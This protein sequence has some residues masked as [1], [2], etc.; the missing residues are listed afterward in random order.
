[1]CSSD[2]ENFER[3]LRHALFMYFLLSD[4]TNN[5]EK[6]RK[7]T[8]KGW[9]KA[10][11]KIG[12]DKLINAYGGLPKCS[13][14][15]YR[16]SL[17]RFELLLDVPDKGQ[18]DTVMSLRKAITDP[19]SGK[20]PLDNRYGLALRLAESIYLLHAAGLVHKFIRPESFLLIE[21]NNLESSERYPKRLGDPFLYDFL[22]V[23]EDGTSTGEK[24][25]AE[26]PKRILLYRS[27]RHSDSDHRDYGEDSF[28]MI[29]DIYSVGVCLLEIGLWKS[30]FKRDGDTY[31]EDGNVFNF[32]ERSAK[33]VTD[34]LIAL[35]KKELPSKVGFKYT[36]IV[37][38]ILSCFK[39]QSE[40]KFPLKCTPVE[41][42]A[43]FEEVVLKGL[44]ALL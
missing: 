23:M 12:F 22:Q 37:V 43:R 1:M 36:A 4:D 10:E 31:V 34:D 32:E 20:H 3:E 11:D 21:Q 24:T 16:R 9:E 40:S 13:G 8:E 44:R 18:H 38:G 14:V 5:S 29:D 17:Q 6:Q 19:E 30:F 33:E 15:V 2:L 26:Y 28:R 7:T 41:M 39:D 42:N 25:S 35:A 27:P